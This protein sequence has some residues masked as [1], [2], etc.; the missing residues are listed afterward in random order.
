MNLDMITTILTVLISLTGIGT[1]AYYVARTVFK[2]QLNAANSEILKL[3][4]ELGD[5]KYEYNK[6]CRTYS[7]GLTTIDNKSTEIL[8]LEA[9]LEE[10]RYSYKMCSAE[11]LFWRGKFQL[12]NGDEGMHREREKWQKL[13]R[14][15]FRPEG[16]SSKQNQD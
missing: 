10:R 3:I 4:E 7:N 9:Q 13:Y 11:M 15:S 2:G 14:M 8:K 12:T 6:V 5:L 1:T 16:V